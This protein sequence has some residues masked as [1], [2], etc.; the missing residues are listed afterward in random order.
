VNPDFDI[1]KSVAATLNARLVTDYPKRQRIVG[2]AGHGKCS[3]DR[4]AT[5][6]RRLCRIAL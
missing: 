6:T 1:G 5:T 3:V 4:P 2:R